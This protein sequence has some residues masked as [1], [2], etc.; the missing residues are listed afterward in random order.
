MRAC[1]SCLNLDAAGASLVHENAPHERAH[2]NLAAQ[3]LKSP[4]EIVGKG[5][6]SASGIVIPQKVRQPQHRIEHKRSAPR[7]R[8]PVSAIAGEQELQ[9]FIAEITI[10]SFPHRQVAICPEPFGIVAAKVTEQ[11]QQIDLADDLKELFQI[12]C[13][14]RKLSS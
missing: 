9:L 10:Q 14:I 12:A 8:A 5:L 13:F 2:Q 1:R 4:S 3:L 11:S 7:R 6:R